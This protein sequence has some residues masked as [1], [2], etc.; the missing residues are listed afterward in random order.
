MSAAIWAQVYRW[1]GLG[2]KVVMAA[3]SQ[4]PVAPEWER[5]WIDFN[6]A[7]L[8]AQVAREN[9][10]IPMEVI[11]QFTRRKTRNAV[12]IASANLQQ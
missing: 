11:Q 2:E 3:P 12:E 9:P 6:T 4:G 10:G 8:M 7:L 5:G 1:E